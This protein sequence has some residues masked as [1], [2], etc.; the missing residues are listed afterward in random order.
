[1]R[2]KN[3]P[4]LF[5]TCRIYVL[6]FQLEERGMRPGEKLSLV[7]SGEIRKRLSTWK[8]RVR[9]FA[10][11]GVRRCSSLARALGWRVPTQ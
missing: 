9:C 7:K 3:W 6:D 5:R 10:F 8:V 4:V 2:P 11:D 1:M